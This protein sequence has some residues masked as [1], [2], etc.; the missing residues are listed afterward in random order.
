MS[1][2]VQIAGVMLRLMGS[3]GMKKL[4]YLQ[5]YLSF[6]ESEPWFDQLVYN[7][8]SWSDRF[9]FW[10]YAYNNSIIQMRSKG[11]NEAGSKNNNIS[12]LMSSIESKLELLAKDD[13]DTSFP[14]FNRMGTEE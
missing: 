9:I 5:E 12:Q 2:Y 4:E 10:T 6:Q 13:F 14:Q 7:Q 3:E 8:E 1:N 11:T